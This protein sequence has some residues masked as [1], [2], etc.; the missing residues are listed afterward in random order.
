M[1]HART[2]SSSYDI[3]LPESSRLLNHPS[4]LAAPGP[5]GLRAELGGDLKKGR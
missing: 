3:R 4:D 1:V 2:E 5:L